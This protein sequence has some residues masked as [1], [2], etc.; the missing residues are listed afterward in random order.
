M[1]FQL[2]FHLSKQANLA[3]ASYPG[4]FE[5]SENGPGYEARLCDLS[6]IVN[7]TRFFFLYN[8]S[9]SCKDTIIAIC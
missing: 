3:L 2:D 6:N 1:S 4:P 5:K 8:N 7:H 9:A